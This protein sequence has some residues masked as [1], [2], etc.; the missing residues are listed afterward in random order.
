MRE[1]GGKVLV[2]GGQENLLLFFSN[3]E[4]TMLLFTDVMCEGGRV[5]IMRVISDTLKL[6]DGKTRPANKLL[7]DLLRQSS[8][9]T[10]LSLP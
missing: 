10:D 8:H 3:E 9:L 4:S 5:C 7:P 6:L 1:G 2:M